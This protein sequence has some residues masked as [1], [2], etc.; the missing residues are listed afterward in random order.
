MA[1]KFNPVEEIQAQ[2][3]SASQ[4]GVHMAVRIENVEHAKV[5]KMCA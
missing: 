3:G 5:L 4:K 1:L 2:I